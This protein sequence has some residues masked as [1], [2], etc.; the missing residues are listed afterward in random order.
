ME[1]S[2]NLGHERKPVDKLDTYSPRLKTLSDECQTLGCIS[3]R[4]CDLNAVAGAVLRHAIQVL[5]R[6]FQQ[7]EPLIFKIGFTH[8][9]I[10]RWSNA[11][12]G[13]G[14]AREKW[15]HMI[16]LYYSKEP[17]S[18]AMLEAALIEKYQST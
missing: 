15:S 17:Y 1:S 2:T 18:P 9:P 6:L 16:I 14:V 8:N 5:E 11:S 13:Y 12:Y 7:Q 4:L 3:L 10:W